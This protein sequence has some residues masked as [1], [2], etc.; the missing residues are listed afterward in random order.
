MEIPLPSDFA[1]ASA[2][3][4]DADNIQ[5][6]REVLGLWPV[7]TPNKHIESLDLV[8]AVSVSNLD[9][10]FRT[11]D[12][13]EAYRLYNGPL[14]Y[15]FQDKAQIFHHKFD[16]FYW[17]G[18]ELDGDYNVQEN[19]IGT[20]LGAST[21]EDPR[22]T[23]VANMLHLKE[24]H[25]ANDPL[26]NSYIQN[27]YMLNTDKGSN[28]Y[29]NQIQKL[30]FAMNQHSRLSK[31]AR[32]TPLHP[33][34]FSKNLATG[35]PVHV[36]HTAKRKIEM[37]SAAGVVQT[38]RKQS[39]MNALDSFKHPHAIKQSV[40][41]FRD[42]MSLASSDFDDD[43]SYNY[44]PS[45]KIMIGGFINGTR[46]S[47]PENYKYENVPT[48][49]RNSA[50]ITLPITQDG[51]SDM[52]AEG[53]SHNG[54]ENLFLPFLGT[55]TTN[56]SHFSE[57]SEMAQA[58]VD[59]FGGTPSSSNR[60]AT[61][62]ELQMLNDLIAE[63]EKELSGDIVRDEGDIE[64]KSRVT[65]LLPAGDQTD[66]IQYPGSFEEM[67]TPERGNVASRPNTQGTSDLTVVSDLTQTPFTTEHIQAMNDAEKES[68]R[69]AR[70]QQLREQYSS[71]SDQQ[72]LVTPNEQTMAANLKNSYTPGGVASLNSD[73][74]MESRQPR[75]SG[76][77]RQLARDTL[78]NKNI[79]PVKFTPQ[80]KISKIAKHYATISAMSAEE[81]KLSAKP[82]YISEANRSL[83]GDLTK[84]PDVVQRS[85]TEYFVN[86]LRDQD[87]P[88]V[89]KLQ[90]NR[91]TFRGASIGNSN[92]YIEVKSG[93]RRLRIQKAFKIPE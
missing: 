72:Q 71:T 5:R 84:I 40:E 80:Q 28:Y 78:T 12:Y 92:K 22:M 29:Q 15:P 25:G 66:Q 16:P 88:P 39:R 3:F 43:A 9:K 45:N 51:H 90:W 68:I 37:P 4:T 93:K 7:E 83:P 6:R 27:L 53:K 76:D 26:D 64:I 34:Q 91:E 18:S 62:Q 79:V 13:K 11:N 56:A 31:A 21:L 23:Y 42:T 58:S 89:G 38:S 10:E 65:F 75:A 52:V 1:Q 77:A 87:K 35:N 36:K 19:L 2:L 41:T 30:D 24:L 48:G 61:T 17:D 82:V 46:D 44:V 63:N 49:R 54:Q 32:H 69:R 8:T 50:I 73:F 67:K 60:T 81:P 85:R 55:P 20:P 74:I 86:T 14:Q 47:H 70:I 57:T 33:I 59:I